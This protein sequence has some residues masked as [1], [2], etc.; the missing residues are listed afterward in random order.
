MF[1]IILIKND[2]KM[3]YVFDRSTRMYVTSDK[4]TNINAMRDNLEEGVND[5]RVFEF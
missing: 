4:S 2:D 3:D 5:I 1:S